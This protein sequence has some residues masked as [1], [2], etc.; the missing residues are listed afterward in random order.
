MQFQKEIKLPSILKKLNF[1]QNYSPFRLN[2]EN[3]SIHS[4]RSSGCQNY[5]TKHLKICREEFLRLL[6]A[7][8]CFCVSTCAGLGPALI[9][10]CRQLKESSEPLQLQSRHYSAER[11]G[12]REAKHALTVLYY[13][14]PPSAA[15]LWFP[16][17]LI[18]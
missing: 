7:S 17:F 14:P 9:Y 18:K 6:F 5:Q 8:L 3:N 11:N 12:G 4:T 16:K 1:I 13:F 2:L 10:F 15:E